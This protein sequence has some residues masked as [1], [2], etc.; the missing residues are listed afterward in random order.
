[1]IAQTL[2]EEQLNEFDRMNGGG[3]TTTDT[4]YDFL[5]RCV[6]SEDD[7]KN[8]EMKPNKKYL[9][10]ICEGTMGEIFG[11]RGIGKTWLRDAIAY[12]LTRKLNLG[13]FISNEPAGVLIVDGEMSLNLLKDRQRLSEHLPAT[14][15]P[16]DIISNEY[17]YCS[18]NPVI[19]L[20]DP[21]W[22]DAFLELI[23]ETSSRWDVIIFDNLSSFLPG[24][25]EN[26]QESW[27]PINGFFL[28]LKWMGKAVIF[29][30]HAGKSGDQRGTSGREDQ[31][32]FVLKLTLPAGHDP[33][34]G[35]KFDAMLT[36]SRSLTGAEAAP[37][38]FEIVE[39]ENGGLTWAVTNQRE[40]R[41]EIIIALLGNGVSQKSISD[42]MRVDK[43]YVCRTRTA[44]IKQ[45]LL[46]DS[47]TGF[48]AIGS[49]KY[50]GFDVEKYVS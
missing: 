27:A 42:L 36:K 9:G 25:K 40:S 1:M 6:L 21:L 15:K 50:G 24:I 3:R 34:D 7:L 5:V 14:I 4:F 18:G 44:A 46:N 28:Q 11:P 33:A 39:H 23:K 10:P 20:S 2:S 26:D 45:K 41:K 12:C 43:A 49:L 30:H 22:R 29:I 31:L 8:L 38:T 13:P 47:G 17:L 35:C 48:T 19:N 37:F 32:D 16:L